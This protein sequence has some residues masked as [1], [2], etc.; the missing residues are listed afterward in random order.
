VR[1]QRVV[2]H[3]LGRHLRCKL[4]VEPTRDVDGSH[5]GVFLLGPHSE[6]AALPRKIGPFGV[7]LRAHRH[8]LPRR[9]R[10]R[11]GDKASHPGNDDGVQTG[12]GR[13][14]AE[15]QASRR[16]DAIVG[17]EN[18]GT[19]PSDSVRSVRFGVSHGFTA[20]AEWNQRSQVAARGVL[21]TGKGYYN[22][23]S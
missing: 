3:E 13:R 18:C 19:K 23:S 22:V 16:H 12:T 14:D 15:D 5:L 10:H 9:H 20:M 8:V 11:P 17:A 4:R 6:L 21:K 1:A 2:L 7:R